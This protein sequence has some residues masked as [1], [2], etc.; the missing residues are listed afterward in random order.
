MYSEEGHFKFSSLGVELGQ[1]N[2]HVKS[3]F[4]LVLLPFS[5]IRPSF[6]LTFDLSPS[7]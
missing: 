4:Q 3:I 1:R 7:R 2:Q 6:C 5:S